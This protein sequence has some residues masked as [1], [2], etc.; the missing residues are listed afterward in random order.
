MK[1]KG[2]PLIKVVGTI[3]GV[4]AVFLVD[5]G[6]TTEFVDEGFVRRAGIRV[7]ASGSSIK[8]AD[9]ATT[10]SG[11]ITEG[12]AC[13]VQ[14][15]AGGGDALH[16]D[17][18]LEVTKLEGYD[19][20]L[21]L[22]WF[23]AVKPRFEWSQVVVVWVPVRDND[24]KKRWKALKLET[25]GEKVPEKPQSVAEEKVGGGGDGKEQQ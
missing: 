8:L 24:G 25:G 15:A 21:G 17:G 16:W 9:G 18:R 19:A 22:T 10:P 13:S 1:K 23:K 5:S 4:R 6:A 2:E 11:G 14:K 7:E 3:G 20:I 12:V